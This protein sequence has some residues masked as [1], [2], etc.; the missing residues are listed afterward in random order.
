[1]NTPEMSVS[2]AITYHVNSLS[3]R[4]QRWYRV[5]RMIRVD[6]LW[7]EIYWHPDHALRTNK[8]A[9]LRRLARE[10]GIDLAQGLFFDSDRIGR[11]SRE[12]MRVK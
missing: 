7:F 11:H 8:L 10:R 1:M 12:M 2:W 9:T 3:P 6:G 5:V 4:A